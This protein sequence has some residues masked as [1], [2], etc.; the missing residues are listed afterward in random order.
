MQSISPEGSATFSGVVVEFAR[1]G[2]WEGPGS[3]GMMGFSVII[4]G[5]NGLS[6]ASSSRDLSSSAV[7][8]LETHVV[9]GC[10]EG[11]V[12]GREIP[13]GEMRYDL[14]KKMTETRRGMA[15]FLSRTEAPLLDLYSYDDSWRR[16]HARMSDSKADPRTDKIKGQSGADEKK[17]TRSEWFRVW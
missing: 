14:Q 11:E 1:E 12:E 4:L 13:R 16:E 2:G 5:K 7:F 10:R 15:G 3:E 17:Q 9:E 8:W 6:V